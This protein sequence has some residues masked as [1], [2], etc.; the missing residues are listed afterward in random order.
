MNSGYK[1][2]GLLDHMGW[3]NLG[4]AAV[5]ESIISNIRRRLPNARLVAFSL[6]PEDT[7]ARHGLTS[8]PITWS[9]PRNKDSVPASDS[10]SSKGLGLGPRLKARLKEWRVL[11]A[12]TKPIHDIGRE[13]GHLISSRR[14]VKSLDLLIISGGG[15]L[16][17]LWRGPWSHP[18]NVFKFCVLAKLSGTP[19]FI[20]GVGAG[21]LRHPL[22]RFFARWSVRLA[23][24]ASFRDVESQ[25][26]IHNLGPSA[27]TYV[28]PDPAYALDLR[29]CVTTSHPQKARQK[30]GL[31]PIGFCDP[32]IW[33]RQDDRAYDLYLEKL[34]TF[35]SWLLAHDYDVEIFTGEISVDRYAIED[36]R[37]RLPA[38]MLRHGRAKACC[39]P[40][41]SLKDL[42]V[43][44]STFDFVITSKFHGVIFSHLLGKPVI[45]LSYH[46]KIQD[47]MRASQHGQYC[48]D[49]DNFEVG[50]LVNV[51]GL[52]VD[53]NDDLKARF[54]HTAR[55]YGSAL[56]AQF[57]ELF[58]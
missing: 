54:H 20:I 30:V 10:H 22:S 3:G 5:Q 19:I 43:Q 23:A 8:Y 27:K 14:L 15:Q 52:L 49:I 29:D 33:P 24:Y 21:P 46:H 1:T 38:S 57:D 42:L 50:S 26:L 34:A 13:L 36:L 7:E 32:R 40:M 6:N 18:Y 53:N 11:Y 28:C 9:F 12:V 58:C 56:Q 48:L 37:R 39:H 17:E 16:S 55:M 25:T 41:Y 47:L 51:F 4:D 44:M 45:A 31:N 35:S 2:I